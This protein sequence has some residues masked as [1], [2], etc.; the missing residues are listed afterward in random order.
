MKISDYRASQ[1]AQ[2][3]GL[4]NVADGSPPKSKRAAQRSDEA[5]LSAEARD[6]LKARRA[7]Q[8]ASD[9]R[10]D[11][12]AELQR[13]VRNGTYPLDEEALARRLVQ[14]LDLGDG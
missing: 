12:V 4:Q 10:A 8:E 9:V 14:L 5:S 3:Y 7:A 13:Q 6:L 2:T 11:L 1:V